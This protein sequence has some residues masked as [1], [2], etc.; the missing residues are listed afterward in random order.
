MKK[1]KFSVFK[2]IAHIITQ[3]G[4]FNKTKFRCLDF[5]SKN[6]SPK[7]L[8]KIHVS[9][10]NLG[11]SV[12]CGNSLIWLDILLLLSLFQSLFTSEHKDISTHTNNFRLSKSRLWNES[13]GLLMA[14]WL[15]APGY[16]EVMNSI[17][18]GIK[19]ITEPGIFFWR[20]LT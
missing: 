19:M 3:V 5:W 13:V 11:K 2:E 15:G 1:L 8:Q 7:N 4:L 18:W 16:R 9:K 14:N 6:L 20:M 10:S 12:Y 17:L